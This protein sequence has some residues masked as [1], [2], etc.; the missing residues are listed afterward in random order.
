M[1]FILDALKKSE[2]DRQRQN[3]VEA[4]YLPDRA[5]NP[6]PSRWLTVA[7]ILLVINIA[8]LAVVLLKPG[9]ERP[10]AVATEPVAQPERAPA[11]EDPSFREMVTEAK[12]T[13]QTV[14]PATSAPPPNQQ[15]TDTQQSTPASQTPQLASQQ[16]QQQAPPPVATAQPATTNEPPAAMSSEPNAGAAVYPTFNEVRAEGIVDLPPLRIDIHVYSENAADR[17]VFINM[18]RHK[19]RSTLSEGPQIL[20]I[21]PEGVVLEYRGTRFVLP[22]E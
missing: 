21:V 8:V 10:A 6:G 5:Q 19:E 11:E 17:F 14:T 2:A 4:A 9:A 20:E 22:R 13:Q 7:V 12:R 1:S 16:P 15:Q 3:S 18:N